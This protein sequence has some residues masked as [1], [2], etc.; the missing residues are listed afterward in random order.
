MYILYCVVKHIAFSL[1]IT[2]LVFLN[3]YFLSI[4]RFWCLE[5]C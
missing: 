2:L 3:K 1:I 4:F 5:I